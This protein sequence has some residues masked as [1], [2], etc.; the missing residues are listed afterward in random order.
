MFAVCIC[1]FKLDWNIL[2]PSFSWNIKGRQ[3]FLWVSSLWPV[4]WRTLLAFFSSEG[5]HFAYHWYKLA[6]CFFGRLSRLQNAIY[7]WDAVANA[8]CQFACILRLIGSKYLSR[9]G[10]FEYNWTNF[11]SLLAARHQ[12]S[13]FIN[14]WISYCFQWPEASEWMALYQWPWL[15]WNSQADRFQMLVMYMPLTADRNIFQPG[16]SYGI[17]YVHSLIGIGKS[18]ITK[19]FTKKS[20]DRKAYDPVVCM[21]FLLWVF[22]WQTMNDNMN[23]WK[24]GELVSDIQNLT[25]E[26]GKEMH[27][28]A[29]VEGYSAGERDL[30]GI[31]ETEKLLD[32]PNSKNV[33]KGKWKT[34]Q[35]CIS[36]LIEI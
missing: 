5:L 15:G 30:S 26:K 27:T 11:G 9:K 4:A 16:I 20:G 17:Y 28:T 7:K 24:I 2:V 33:I 35:S 22:S 36:R 25:Y 13:A 10:W 29:A 32:G 34:Q 6:A 8:R 12:K 1:S 3:K 21:V 31:S 18:E 14:A 23:H 19:R